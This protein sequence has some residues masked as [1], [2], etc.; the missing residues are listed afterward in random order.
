MPFLL[1]ACSLGIR[2]WVVL[3][4]CA[5]LAASAA[6]DSAGDDVAAT[7]RR[8]VAQLDGSELAARQRA[9]AQLIK[10][11]PAALAFLPAV[12]DRTPAETAERLARVRQSLELARAARAAEA[13]LVTIQGEL[14][15]GELLKELARQSGNAISDRRARRPRP[16]RSWRSIFTTSHSGKPST[17]CSIA[18]NWTSTVT[19]GV[20]G[21][22]SCRGPGRV[23]RAEAASYAGAIRIEPVRFEEVADLRK[24]A[25]RSLKLLIEVDWEPRL[26]PILVSQSLDAVRATAGGQAAGGRRPRRDQ[27]AG[28]RRAVGDFAGDSA[29]RSAAV[30][31]PRSVRSRASSKMLLP[32]DVEVFR[33]GSLS[34]KTTAQHKPQQHKGAVTVTLEDLRKSGDGWD[35]EVSARFDDPNLAI[36]SYLIGW[37]LD[38]K[39]T[40]RARG[41]RAADAGLD[42]ANPPDAEGSRRQI[43]FRPGRKPGGLVAG[44]CLADRGARDCRAIPLHKPGTSLIG[45]A[46]PMARLWSLVLCLGIAG[47]GALSSAADAPPS[48][49]KPTSRRSRRL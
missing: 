4:A 25:G 42:A 44:L 18:R 8:L 30:R 11:G 46:G 2:P 49:P 27:R 26:R 41:S 39:V 13:S 12:T 35:A 10:L 7:V 16:S 15:V 1:R 24:P 40:L 3:L 31:W 17:K 33:F 43:P 20:P 6:A 29:G 28:R 19:P 21:W 48:R 32:A 22:P 38:N 14:P 9:E 45:S 5:A 23:P 47:G 36:D 34:A 37:L